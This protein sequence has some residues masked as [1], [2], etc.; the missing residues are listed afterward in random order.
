LLDGAFVGRRA[1][2]TAHRH[3]AFL[4][5]VLGTRA[6]VLLALNATAGI[7]GPIERVDVTL[8]PRGARLV[9]PADEPLPHGPEPARGAATLSLRRAHS[10]SGLGHRP[11]TAAARVRIPY[12]PL[13]RTLLGRRLFARI[14]GRRAPDA[15][16]PFRIR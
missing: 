4:D 10:S 8:L 5:D 16:A 6:P 1:A 9:A 14:S 12:A 13:S 11:L 7:A 2:G 15:S 3:V